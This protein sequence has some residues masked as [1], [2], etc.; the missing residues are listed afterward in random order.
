MDTQR[1]HWHGRVQLTV[2]W[3][4]WTQILPSYPHDSAQFEHTAVSLSC[5][6][7]CSSCLVLN[8]AFLHTP[9]LRQLHWDSGLCLALSQ[10]F[11]S[12]LEEISAGGKCSDHRLLKLNTHAEQNR[13]LLCKTRMWLLHFVYRTSNT[14]RHWSVNYRSRAKEM[15]QLWISLLSCI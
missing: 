15:I 13:N 10:S 3:R 12:L 9:T 7:W 8:K 2:P 1:C 5:W 6:P 11:S 14:C 4:F